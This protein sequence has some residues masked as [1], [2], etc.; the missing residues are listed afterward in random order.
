[1]GAG[2]HETASSRDNPPPHRPGR[3]PPEDESTSFTNRRAGHQQS[4]AT[5]QSVGLWWA[6]VLLLVD[7]P[8]ARHEHPRVDDVAIRYDSE[9][10]DYRWM[11]D[12]SPA[13]GGL[14][15]WV[16]NG[17]IAEVRP[18]HSVPVPRW[19][20][21]P[22]G[23]ITDFH[24]MMLGTEG[25]LSHPLIPSGV[26]RR[27]SPRRARRSVGTSACSASLGRSFQPASTWLQDGG[28]ACV[29][30]NLEGRVL[31]R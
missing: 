9:P 8:L 29:R 22:D 16:F 30:R 20:R 7:H 5:W 13:P 1:V 27:A 28:V 12:G 23:S 19:V 4:Q 14:S 31:S 25:A 26:A 18:A 17:A 11:V 21:E 24:F 10:P 3:P 6:K 2:S 15:L